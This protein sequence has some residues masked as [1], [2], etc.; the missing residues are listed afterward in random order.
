MA[1]LSQ[2]AIYSIA[3]A[4]GLPN[5]KIMAAIAM[6]ESG[7]NTRAH[8]PN[9]GT[10]DN[11]Y[12][13]WQINMLG[14]MGPARRRE[15]GISRNEDL[16]DPFINA[17]AAKKIQASQGLGAWS[18]YSS[19]AYRKFLGTS[20]KDEGI[21]NVADEEDPCELLKGTP[22]YKYCTDGGKPG[23]DIPDPLD[24]ASGFADALKKTADFL[25]NPRSYLRIA[26]GLGG[27]ILI[28]GG[29]FLMAEKS[30]GVTRTARVAKSVQKGLS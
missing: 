11:S 12:G 20:V 17:R 6:A 23:E 24:V 28:L 30:T 29:L 27:G 13:L 8:N 19:G 14:A 2:S 15:F 22:T 16:F 4:S 9:A 25:V 26:Y 18:V 7:G 5:P 3:L 21:E 10:G 1:R